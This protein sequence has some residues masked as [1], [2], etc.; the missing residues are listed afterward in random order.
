MAATAIF[1][2]TYLALSFGRVPGLRSDR[3]AA[4]IIGAVMLVAFRVLSFGEAQ[5]AVDGATLGL[6]FGMMVL[7]AALDVSGAFAFAA[8]WLTK[9]ARSPLG[10]LTS[11]SIGAAVLS[12]FLINDVVCI[13]FTPFVLGVCEEIEC[14]PKPYLLALATSSNI[15]SVATITG[16]PQNILIASISHITYARFA[17]ALAP[18]AAL[19]LAVNVAIVWLVHRDALTRNFSSLPQG[20][21]SRPKLYRRWVT[22]STALSA[23]VVVAFVLGASPALAALVGASLMLFTRAVNPKRLYERVDWPLLALFVGLFVVT[24]GVEKGG[25]ADLLLAFSRPLHPEKVAGLTATTAVLSNLASNV[26]AV[27]VMKSMVPKLAHPETS[28]LTLAMASTLAGNL[29][30]PGSLASIIVVERAKNRVKISFWDFLRVGAP[31]AIVSL[32]IGIAWLTLV[33]RT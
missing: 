27:M 3:L 14:D 30:L 16:N 9:H 12:A 21:E 4:T 25:L 6:L 28:W 20:D 10:L 15:G 7:S 29:T 8:W 18:V 32:L 19:S 22:K 5:A 31:S 1:V 24:A 11:I 2:F 26:P 13:A 23:A 17:F 33:A